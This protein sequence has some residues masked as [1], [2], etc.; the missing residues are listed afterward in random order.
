MA[1]FLCF[2]A[3]VPVPPAKSSASSKGLAAAFDRALAAYRDTCPEDT[4]PTGLAGDSS[5]AG[6]IGEAG[7]ATGV[8]GSVSAASL[9]AAERSR[10]G[11]WEHEVSDPTA[12]VGS[13]NPPRW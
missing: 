8:G 9:L 2:P 4:L 13:S 3:S 10:S 11:P 12:R 7:E 6:A 1:S 5:G